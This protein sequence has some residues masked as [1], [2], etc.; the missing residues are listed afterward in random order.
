V[1]KVGQGSEVIFP[2]GRD[3]DADETPSATVVR[4]DRRDKHGRVSSQAQQ[5]SKSALT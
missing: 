4:H 2:A 5:S 1:V 3:S